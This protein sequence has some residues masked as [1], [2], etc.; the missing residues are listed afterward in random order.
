M[1]D[2][3]PVRLRRSWLFVGGAD[4]AALVAA[5]R[6]GADVMI[7]E[8]E[9]FTRPVDRPAVRAFAPE[10]LAAWKAA[11]AVAAVRINP[12]SDGGR[13][14][15]EATM[16]GAPHVV[17][18]PKVADPDQ[19]AALDEEV[20]RIER[21]YGLEP[22]ATELVPNIELARGLVQTGAIAR[23]SR[24]VTACLVAAEDMATD[25][26]AE[27]GRDGEELRYVRARFHVECVAAGVV[28]I[29]CPYTWTDAAGL[30]AET[31]HA[32]RLGYT[33][34][35]A[36]EAEHIAVINR[37]LTPSAEE[38]ARARRIVTAFEAARE[39]GEA[40]VE[41][42]GAMI[43]VPIYMNA[44]RLLERATALGVA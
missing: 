21:N 30:E 16:R 32:R 15:L 11:D 13:E 34:K 7:L 28:S 40:R 2:R 8:L 27:R 20:A 6:W 19:V 31:R 37:V 5:A 4:G 44:R 36:V 3:R 9:D 26:G 24:R 38:V 29:D 23:A 41:V 43:E 10:V 14:D 12:L 35:S 22:G 42:D 33:A 17:M 25:L 18:L 1:T 39:A